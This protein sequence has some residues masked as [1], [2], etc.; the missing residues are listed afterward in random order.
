M[1]RI[2]D[3][4]DFG[5]FQIQF[6]ISHPT[7]KLLK[8]LLFVP[9]RPVAEHAVGTVG[10]RQVLNNTLNASVR[11]VP[12]QIG[13]SGFRL[14]QVFKQVWKDGLCVGFFYTHERLGGPDTIT[15]TEVADALED[16]RLST[17]RY[18][19]VWEGG[20]SP[21]LL[22]M[23]CIDKSM[24]KEPEKEIF[25]TGDHLD[26]VTYRKGSNRKAV[27]EEGDRASML[28]AKRLLERLRT[29]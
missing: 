23:V 29:M 28:E 20:E 22:S 16:L 12:L 27:L 26:L 3:L 14:T 24:R 6:Y 10:G 21:G 13:R 25:V 9:L 18:S 2:S 17:W 19:H 11:E 8:S 7:D 5:C 4:S 1:Q 15:S